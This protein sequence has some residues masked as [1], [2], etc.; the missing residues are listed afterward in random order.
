[1]TFIESVT[2]EVDDP[3]AAE[4]FYKTAF[5]LDDQIRLRASEAPTTGFRGF[6]LSLTVSRPATVRGFVDAAVEAGA[7]PVKPV[8]KS[9][10]GHGG[11]VQAP[12]GTIWK[13]A[14]SEKKDTGPA[15]REI[16]DI[17]LLLGVADM[18]ASKR[19]YVDHGL[20]VA[21]SYGRK[22]VEFDSA[23]GSVTLALYGRRA[24]ARTAGVHPDGTGS[25]RLAI[26]AGSG[27]FTDLDGFA[28]EGTR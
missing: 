27:P 22:Y 13:V 21:K 10:W 16:D 1:M 11:V 19:F 23:P 12:D 28:W 6:T 8:A 24:L 4:L 25:H 26:G 7:S 3:A 2:L 9:L 14:T 18:A 5:G 15:T 17:V 20:T